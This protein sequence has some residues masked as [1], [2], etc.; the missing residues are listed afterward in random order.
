MRGNLRVYVLACLAWYLLVG[1]WKA[2]HVS[3]QPP[4]PGDPGPHGVT[5]E[6]YNFGDT[7]F[8]PTDFAVLVPPGRVEVLASVH[9]PTDLSAGPFPL[10]LFLHG[11]HVTCFLGDAAFLQWPC[12]PP[13]QPIPSYQGYDY[14]TEILASHGYIVVSVSANGINA[15]DNSVADRGMLARAELIQHHLNIWERF[16]TT[17]GE[18]FGTTFVGKVDL[19]NV[20]TL[21]HSRGGEG[22]VRHF[23]FNAAQGS[24]Y[25]I[26][27]VMP[28]AP[29]DY[30]R[31]V[32]NRVPLA[33]PLPYCDGDVPDLLGVHFFDDARYNVPGDRA[34][35]HTLLIMGANHNFYNTF[36][37]PEVFT[38]GSRDD[39]TAFVVDGDSD[40]HCG[41]VPGN[42]RLTA[43]QQRGTGRA[44]FTAF[45]RTYLGGESDFLAL[46][47][48]DAPPPPSA[49][50]EQIFVS[51]HPPDHPLHRR[52]VNRLLSATDLTSNTLGGAVT[53]TGLT[54]YDLCGGEKPQPRHCLPTPPQPTAR[55]PHTAPSALAPARR[56]LSQLRFGWDAA[57]AT[58]QNELPA[59][60]R[61]VSGYSAFQFRASINFEDSRNPPGAPQDFSV[62]LTDGAG[63]AATVRVSDWSAAL[64]FP[65]GRIPPSPEGELL[66]VPKIVLN[67]VRIP[68][69]AFRAATEQME[70]DLTDIR[71]VRF[72][73]DQRPSGAL[74]IADI[75]FASEFSPVTLTLGLNQAMFR[76]G[77]TLRVR[78]GIH[79]QG[80][81]VTMDVYLGI[82][83][84]DGVTVFFVTSL[85]PLD[86][87]VTRLDTDPRT[88]APLAASFEFPPE[89]DV[90]L[91]DFFVYTF[92]GG[93]SPGSYTIFTL[94][95]PPGAFTDGQVDA[96]DLL[97]LTL[98]PFTVSP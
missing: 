25:S 48:G 44:Y 46:F 51:Y 53:H 38:P 13:R 33:V 80:P 60:T 62:T 14:A 34:P 37:T 12:T 17:G 23:L 19:N 18:P 96:G 63:N 16:S 21:G 41:S 61:D 5:R 92:T 29:V 56:G 72:D 7:A 89:L 20:G 57:G 47:T 1:G 94:L 82:L 87:V 27:A 55:Q 75:A 40:P 69:S 73:F 43:E 10:V 98:Q 74:L 15:R 22:V 24:P 9:Y 30:N 2:Q 68:L 95:T 91:E 97:G 32:I 6:E 28:L 59:G 76:A 3:A 64:F 31:P 86:G 52:D 79:H 50:T 45:F 70:V 11:R 85:A 90:T 35:K 26:K 8:T 84:P 58:Y 39:W 4:D 49:M 65:P 88:F 54:L 78:L 67:T 66:P 83:L 36:W 77:E 93:E 71:T 42:Q 81:S